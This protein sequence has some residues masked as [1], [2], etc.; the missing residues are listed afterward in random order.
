[1]ET[2][3]LD[4]LEAIPQPDVETLPNATEG[5]SSVLYNF[6]YTLKARIEMIPAFITLSLGLRSAPHN[7]CVRCL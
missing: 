6:L 4:K 3:R 5:L 2:G 7:A 1:M